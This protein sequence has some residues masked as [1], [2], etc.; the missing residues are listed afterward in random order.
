MYK[1]S[2]RGD[3]NDTSILEAGR[4]TEERHLL[5]EQ[6]RENL[7]VRKD[8]PPHSDHHIKVEAVVN[9]LDL[10]LL[11]ICEGGVQISPSYA[12]G[13]AALPSEIHP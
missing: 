5:L 13:S 6:E 11:G 8:A 2:G 10:E 9:P 3:D 12:H 4:W 1:Q 7:C